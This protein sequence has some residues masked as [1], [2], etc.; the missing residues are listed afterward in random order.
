V[1]VIGLGGG[2]ATC[3]N[4]FLERSKRKFLTYKRGYDSREP[5]GRA[6]H[7]RGEYEP[8]RGVMR[9]AAISLKRQVGPGVGTVGDLRTPG[10]NP[11]LAKSGQQ[12]GKVYLRYKRE[13]YRQSPILPVGSLNPAA[14]V[15]F[16]SL[17]WRFSVHF[18]P[19]DLIEFALRGERQGHRLPEY[20]LLDEAQDGSPTGRPGQFR[21]ILGTKTKPAERRLP[22]ISAQAYGNGFDATT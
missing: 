10:S 22:P 3:R 2:G 5:E 18:E 4:L 16:F 15:N 21:Q 7:S 9:T 11:G 20:V 14:P 12:R 17:E 6:A 1:Q 13:P 8:V 19:E